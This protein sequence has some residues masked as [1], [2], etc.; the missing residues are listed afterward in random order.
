MKPSVYIGIDLG[1]T[2]I[3]MGLVDQLGNILHTLESPTPVKAGYHQILAVFSQMAEQLFRKSQYEWKDII[4]VGAGV[5][6]FLDQQKGIVVEAVNLGWDHVPL[7][8][9]LERMWMVPIMVDNDANA[10]ALG[11][12]W[13]GAGK[14]ASHLICLTLGTGIGGGVIINGNIYHGANGCAGEVGHITVK[15]QGGRRCN[16][17]RKGCLETETSAT[18]IVSDAL[19]QV[20]G[21]ST[22]P[23][24]D[25]YDRTGT[26]SAKSVVQLAQQGDSI[27]LEIITKVGCILGNTLAQMCYLLNPEV[28]VI[29][30]GVAHA[31]KILFDPLTKAFNKAILPRVAENTSIVPAKLGNLAGLTGAAWL[32]HR[33]YTLNKP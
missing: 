11:E 21:M 32:I 17:G 33:K 18:A 6:A 28:I 14:G 27:C 23:L 19:E 15:P 5:P 24:K 20:K 22:G 7:K 30:G 26:V 25:E 4:G 2:S 12:M 3:K 13:S 31:G 8:A 1:G 10:A 29:G 9:D 16:C